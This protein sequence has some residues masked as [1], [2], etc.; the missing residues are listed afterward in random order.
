MKD[1]K[2]LIVGHP[3]TLS[4]QVLAEKLANEHTAEVILVESNNVSK[5]ISPLNIL[6]GQVS[7]ERLTNEV[8]PYKMVPMITE[9]LSYLPPGDKRGILVN[10]R[11]TPKVD[12][13]AR[14]KECGLKNKKCKGH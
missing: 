11:T 9:N 13:N 1:N 8:Y 14:C 12:R 6:E 10:V 3:P 5:T 2:I 7:K 4:A